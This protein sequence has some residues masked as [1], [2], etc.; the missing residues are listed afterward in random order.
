MNK[1]LENKEEGM[2]EVTPTETTPAETPETDVTPEETAPDY[3]KIISIIER[4]APGSD[5]SNPDAII[6][7]ATT[8]LE[9][10]VP[11][12]DK[13]YDV[14]IASPETASC[15]NDILE[16]GDLLK[17]VVRN[18]GT[19]QL[20]EV[21]EEMKSGDDYE[22]AR[23]YHSGNVQKMKDRMMELETNKANSQLS[24]QE[25]MDKYQPEDDD[26]EK[27]IA[28]YDGIIKDAIDNNMTLDHWERLWKA[29]KYDSKIEEMEG[30]VS[31]AEEAGK[32]AG[33]NEKIET[34]KKTKADLA[35][36]LPEAASGGAFES[37]TEQPKSFAKKFTD[38]VL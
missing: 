24:A 2:A 29:Y 20:E 30:K 38:G 3:S 23:N 37:K 19:E 21:M 8:V 18:F 14:A 15:L 9:S 6:S 10:M 11:I 35:D 31:E 13:L 1:E 5:T 34:G 22:E 25:F 17:S 7:A 16:T 33:R 28:F 27:F 4:F 12:Y 36:L 26:V 32:I